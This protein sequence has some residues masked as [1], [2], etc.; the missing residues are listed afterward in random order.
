MPSRIKIIYFLSFFLFLF[1]GCRSSRSGLTDKNK[2]TI[3]SYNIRNGTGLDGK[4][5]LERIADIIRKSGAGFVSLQEIDSVTKRS[6]GK[7]I[8]GE[9]A[10]LT[11]LHPVYAAAIVYDGGKYGVGILSKEKPLSVKQ[12]ALPGREEKRVLLVA[13]FKKYQLACTHLSLTREDRMASIP[14]LVQAAESSNKPFILAGDWNDIPQSDFVKAMQQHFVLLNDTKQTTFPAD[15][16]ERDI[17]YIAI[18]KKHP[19]P[20]GI[21]ASVMDEPVASDHRPVLLS[22]KE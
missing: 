10:A 5:D 17:D 14:V 6:N 15:H 20:G 1:C 9:L 21:N 16:P 4:K 3:L 19:I 13:E 12:Y 8:L 22:W 18:Y 11:G 7:Y 2:V